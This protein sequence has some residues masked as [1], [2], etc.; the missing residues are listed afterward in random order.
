L[1]NG[2]FAGDS[3]AQLRQKVKSKRDALSQAERVCLSGMVTRRTLSLD[4]Y[5]VARTVMAYCAHGS[6]VVA[7][8]IIKNAL[9]E[10]KRV[11]VPRVVSRETCEMQAVEIC[12]LDDVAPGEFGIRE[13]RRNAGCVILKPAEIDVVFVPGIAFDGQGY[14]IGYGKG[15]YDRWIKALPARQLVGL[16][17]DFQVLESVPREKY[18]TAVG[19][20]VTDMRIIQCHERSLT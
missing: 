15:F 19:V 20:V 7:D 4:G 8:D 3:K 1:L 13:P 9:S 10:G 12:S 6:E 17:Y 18:D 2:F 14:R 11:V 5:R 16:A